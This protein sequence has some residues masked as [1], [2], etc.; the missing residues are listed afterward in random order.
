MSGALPP[1][2]QYEGNGVVFSLSTGMYSDFS[3]V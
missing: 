1:L 3:F 2:P